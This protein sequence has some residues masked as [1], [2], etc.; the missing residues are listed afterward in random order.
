MEKV[1]NYPSGLFPLRALR[2]DVLTGKDNEGGMTD[3]Q[4]FRSAKQIDMD[5]RMRW[6]ETSLRVLR[7]VDVPTYRRAF[8][9]SSQVATK[10]FARFSD[11]LARLA[12]RGKLASYIRLV[13]GTLRDESG[14]E[15]RLPE[16]PVFGTMPIAVWARVA[17][18]AA[19]E[20]IDAGVM[21]EP[22]HDILAE[23][24]AAIVAGAPLSGG[25]G[26]RLKIRYFSASSGESEKEISPH[27]VVQA[28][29]RHHVRA[30]DHTRNRGADFVLGRILAAEPIDGDYYPRERDPEWMREV[31][32]EL[33]VDARA[34]AATR[35]AMALAY[36]I[37]DDSTRVITT[38][39]ALADYV[40]L[41]Y[42]L[43]PPTYPEPAIRMTVV[44]DRIPFDSGGL[45]ISQDNADVFQP[46]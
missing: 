21:A 35:R 17:L 14:A 15:M 2:T 5:R 23:V 29:G 4:D 46:P 8:N 38:R 34:D 43:R 3:T 7:R 9:L 25:A 33:S 40:V 45:K 39:A 1:E 18:P 36:D 22:P 10:D 30:F 16:S 41:A 26:Y 31:L 28:A 27:T 19:F 20:T 13:R 44:E 37:P 32:L 12:D 24:V 6:I 11:G 42:G